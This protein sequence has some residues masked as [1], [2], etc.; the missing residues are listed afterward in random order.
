MKHTPL[1][2]K[3]MQNLLLKLTELGVQE[4]DIAITMVTGSG[5]GG[6]K[7]NATKNCI[8]LHHLPSDTRIQSQASRSL[9]LNRYR[10]YEALYETLAKKAGLQTAAARKLE[11]LKKQKKR[12]KRRST[13]GED[14]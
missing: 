13:Q 3:K 2:P 12:R 5:K 6:Q 9:E 1:N 8:Q 4:A 11:K 14:S 7:Q 10:A